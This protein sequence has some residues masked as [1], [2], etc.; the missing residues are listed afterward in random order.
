M[1]V[2]EAGGIEDVELVED[3]CSFDPQRK[4]VGGAAGEVVR[5]QLTNAFGECIDELEKS[6]VHPG[7][8]QVGPA[9]RAALD[10][11]MEQRGGHRV[12]VGVLDQ[13]RATRRT[14]SMNS[15]PAL[16]RSSPWARCASRS[17]SITEII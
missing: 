6:I 10:T 3:V 14:W 13:L 8:A 5:L 12:G 9:D 15:R 1:G 17:A 11:V 2:R 16:V 7:V 4:W